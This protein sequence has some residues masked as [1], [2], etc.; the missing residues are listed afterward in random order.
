MGF[1]FGMFGGYCNPIETPYIQ[2]SVNPTPA[3]RPRGP[4]K[5]VTSRVIS[6]LNGPK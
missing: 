4:S 2:N 5:Y 1:G 6:T 3:Q